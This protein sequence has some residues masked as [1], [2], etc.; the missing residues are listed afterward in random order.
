MLIVALLIVQQGVHGPLG[1]CQSADACCVTPVERDDAAGQHCPC[2][3]GLESHPFDATRDDQ[4]SCPGCA[5]DVHEDAELYFS[6]I[7]WSVPVPSLNTRAS[8]I[9][10]LAERRISG[11]RPDAR[12]N[13]PP[14]PDRRREYGVWL[15]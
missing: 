6:S 15:I 8:G 1:A 14:A 3:G 5:W 13:G 2:S 7:S 12:A 9:L 4:G 10:P 11:P